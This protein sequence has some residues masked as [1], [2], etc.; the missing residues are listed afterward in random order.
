[1]IDK[2]TT[3]LFGENR[4][5]TKKD[6]DVK[7]NS[8]SD[9]LPYLACR[10]PLDKNISDL[11][12][13]NYNY[14]YLLKDNS[15]GFIFECQPLVFAGNTFDSLS[16]L[17][18]FPLPPTTVIQT[19]L[20]ADSY[21]EDILNSYKQLR[22]SNPNLSEI[23]KEQIEQY[24]NFFRE[25][26]KNGLWQ[27]S[28]TPMRSYRLYI[29]IK[30]PIKSDYYKDS[31]Q[32]LNEVDKYKDLIDAFVS[33]LKGSYL[34]P[35]IVH[36][37]DLLFLLA[38]IFNPD[39]D[40]TSKKWDQSQPLYK[41][42]I[43]AET[44]IKKD[45]DTLQIGS[46]YAKCI[47]PK[48]FPKMIE[49]TI[50]NDMIGYFGRAAFSSDDDINQIQCPF[51]ISSSFIY[52]ELRTY[53]ETRASQVMIQQAAG[54][55]ANG[56]ALRKIEMSDM[57]TKLEEGEIYLRAI[58]QMWL[59]DNDKD[60][61]SEKTNRVV[62]MWKNLNIETQKESSFILTKLFV[63]A[64]PMGLYGKDYKDLQRDFILPS[65]SAA[66]LMTVQAG[67]KGIGAPYMLFMDR[68]A[69]L[70]AVD[71]LYTG[72]NKNFLI[73][74]GSGGGK[75]FLV[76]YL[77][78]SY[79]SVGCK[80]RIIDVGESYKKTANLFD[81]Q[82]IKFSGSAIILNLFE[83]LGDLTSTESNVNE[84][85]L[86]DDYASKVAILTG[87]IATMAISRTGA[88]AT[89]TQMVLI[90]QAINS[91]IKSKG[92]NSSIDDIA[93]YLA[94]LK[95][96]AQKEAKLAEE[97][98]FLALALQ[99]Y[100][101]G[102]DYGR[103]FSGASN[104]SFKGDL[105]VVELDGVPE[106]LRKVVVLAFASM[107]EDE[108]YNG[109]RQT[110]T[111]III[112]EAWQTLSENP[113][114][115]KFVEGLYR[116]IR[117]YNGSVGIATQSIMDTHPTLGKLKHIGGV[118]RA[119]SNIEFYLPDKDISKAVTGENKLID[120]NEFEVH[121]QINKISSKTLPRY[122]EFFVKS[123][124]GS[125]AVRLSTDEFT[126]FV[127]SSDATDNTFLTFWCTKYRT[128]DM[129]LTHAEGMRKAILKAVEISKK[130]GGIGAFKHYV[131]TEFQNDIKNQE[132]KL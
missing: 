60:K 118:L 30:I 85:E 22:Y 6:L 24:C 8:F 129:N 12:K 33:T 91:S 105:S 93:G 115:A 35:E 99:K 94:N 37:D 55:L 122:S 14:A 103:Y 81:G 73:T 16:S 5:L 50:M 110:P 74:G 23:F 32:Y 20:Y 113:A 124:S 116:K 19:F 1:M 68:R 131:N 111:I 89:E 77:V 120:L 132:I 130:V 125:G 26:S 128:E 100:C 76:N 39:S 36:P 29:S 84:N 78:S 25:G 53:L 28:G 7:R 127:C 18:K 11:E 119:Q 96:D 102:G 70:S 4:G 108:V 92:A 75:S 10:A 27:L 107:I 9:L 112:D 21:I 101:K 117:K 41:Q 56:V 40:I 88:N 52:E 80:V 87:V 3:L 106:D 63:S 48:S 121:Y 86:A 114:A 82:F 67:F 79:L 90:E 69:Q 57:K 95:S 62:T 51:M 83:G 98:H 46:M 58:T 54:T 72:A 66:R 34:A 45:G 31:D 42:I 104:V 71:I 65:K 17:F 49:S 109:D 15:V 64:L 44:S 2:L 59:F 97:G 47:T 43:N 13:K 38:R 123:Q 61:L 126:Y